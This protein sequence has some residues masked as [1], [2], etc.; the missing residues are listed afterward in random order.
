MDKHA[1]LKRTATAAGLLILAVPLAKLLFIVFNITTVS[2][3]QKPLI[4]CLISVIFWVKESTHS[5]V[6]ASKTKF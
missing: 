4:F 2:I 6:D 3:L 1:V 5:K